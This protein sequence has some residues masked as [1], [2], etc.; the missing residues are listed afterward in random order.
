L[1]QEEYVFIIDKQCRFTGEV[2]TKRQAHLGGRLHLCVHLI[3]TDGQANLLEQLRGA[4]AQFAGMADLVSA[5]G[6]ASAP[7]GWDV[8]GF[9]PPD[10]MQLAIDTVIREA[11]EELGIVIE[12]EWFFTDVLRFIGITRTNFVTE[13]GWIDRSVIFNFIVV[14]PGI[15][16]MIPGMKFEAGKVE[17]AYM[18]SA[19]QLEQILLGH[20]PN[21]YPTREPDGLRML[22]MVIDAL[23]R[24]AEGL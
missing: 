21:P 13:E 11:F 12:R 6:H 3:I 5:G 19:N 7:E 4:L 22:A 1:E 10:I 23:R 8:P 20:V 15:A 18:R 17:A 2:M 16:A 9:V 24:I 14:I